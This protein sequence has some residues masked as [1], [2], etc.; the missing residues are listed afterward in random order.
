MHPALLNSSTRIS[1][2]MNNDQTPEKE[3]LV[4]NYP[5]AL[6]GTPPP[7]PV[8][9][10][11]PNRNYIPSSLWNLPPLCFRSF[12][13]SFASCWIAKRQCSIWRPFSM[14]FILFSRSTKS[15]LL[16]DSKMIADSWRNCSCA[17][18][19]E[20]FCCTRNWRVWTTDRTYSLSVH[21]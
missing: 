8:Y 6:H 18:L 21:Q 19:R 5:A 7:S 3:Q 12:T 11:F 20:L 4:Q 14:I 10:H 15:S 1:K 9:F 17:L 13:L 16:T 2:T